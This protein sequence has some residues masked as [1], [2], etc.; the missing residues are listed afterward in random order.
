MDLT[1][2]DTA[3]IRDIYDTFASW[4]EMEAQQ[5]QYKEELSDFWHE[6]R[7]TL[8]AVDAMLTRWGVSHDPPNEGDYP[9]YLPTHEDWM[10]ENERLGLV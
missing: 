10:R 2:E 9:D 8:H 5:E 4:V 3:V 6:R 1:P 7:M